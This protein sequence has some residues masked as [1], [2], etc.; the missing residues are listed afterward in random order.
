MSTKQKIFAA[1][2]AA[3][4]NA[5]F[6]ASAGAALSTADKAPKIVDAETTIVIDGRTLSCKARNGEVSCS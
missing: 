5:A 1:I 4:I 6:L 3:T 2:T